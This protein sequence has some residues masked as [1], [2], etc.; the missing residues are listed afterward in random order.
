M[1]EEYYFVILN[2]IFGCYYF[3]NTN[4]NLPKVSDYWVTQAEFSNGIQTQLGHMAEFFVDYCI[5]AKIKQF[6][7]SHLQLINM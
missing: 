6:Y 5:Y 1:K 3:G 4:C 7:L 2:T